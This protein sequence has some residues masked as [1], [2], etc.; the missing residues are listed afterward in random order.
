MPK[1]KHKYMHKITNSKPSKWGHNIVNMHV[2][3]LNMLVEKNC[4]FQH[5]KHMNSL[6]ILNENLHIL[7]KM[8]IENKS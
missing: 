6:I 7:Y 5:L 1:H 3:K 2:A 8:E 4:I